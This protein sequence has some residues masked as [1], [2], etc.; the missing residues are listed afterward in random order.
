MFLNELK[1]RIEWL[2]EFVSCEF[3]FLVR[4]YELDCGFP[5]TIDIW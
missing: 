5:E 1:G 4:K 2:S 3:I